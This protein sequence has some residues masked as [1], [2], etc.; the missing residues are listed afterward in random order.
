MWSKLKGAVGTY[1]DD[2]L[3]LAAGGCFVASALLV[4]GLPAGLAVAGVWL[5]LC[6]MAVARAKRGERR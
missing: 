6:A 4:G 1:L 3:M 5:A 2:L